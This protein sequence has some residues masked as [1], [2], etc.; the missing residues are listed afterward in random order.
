MS[1]LL[2]LLVTA[3][4]IGVSPQAEPESAN[5]LS[6]SVAL[7]PGY[8]DAEVTLELLRDDPNLAYRSEVQESESLLSRLW[9]GFMRLVERIFGGQ[10]G[11]I[12]RPVLAVVLGAVVLWVIVLIA[13]SDVRVL[14]RGPV[15][16]GSKGQV[17][18]DDI[19]G[20]DYARLASAAE[21]EGDVRAA[22]RWR[23]LLV[24]QHLDATGQS[25]YRPDK[26]HAEHASALAV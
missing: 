9:R 1:R 26:T 10:A 11:F 7:S 23:F 14:A 20:V 3:F 19:S 21:A 16:R 2:L 13:R 24:L 6:D 17:L 4:L 5:A 22:L 15:R 12:T 25:A 8:A 18:P